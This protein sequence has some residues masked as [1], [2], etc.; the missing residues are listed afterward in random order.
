MYTQANTMGSIQALGIPIQPTQTDDTLTTTG[1]I[2]NYKSSQQEINRE[3]QN[4]VYKNLASNGSMVNRH[5]TFWVDK[6]NLGKWNPGRKW[7]GIQ[8][9]R[10]NEFI[11]IKAQGAAEVL[12]WTPSESLLNATL[13]IND[14]G[15]VRRITQDQ[16]IHPLQAEWELL[17]PTR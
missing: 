13:Y 4:T 11:S 17:E 2:V 8:R 3:A 6:R 1:T 9:T 7:R 14:K 5:G 15:V 16:P 10:R 12:L